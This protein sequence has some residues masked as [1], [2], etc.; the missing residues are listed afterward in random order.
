MF[1][2]S[3]DGDDTKDFGPWP[4]RPV[5]TEPLEKM[6][7]AELCVYTNTEF[8]GG[9]G[10]SIVTTPEL[11]EAFAALPSLTDPVAFSQNFHPTDP[12]SARYTRE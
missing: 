2:K 3:G 12:G 11:S 1:L 6:N 8:N 4:Y 10:I 7:G 9:R 5:C